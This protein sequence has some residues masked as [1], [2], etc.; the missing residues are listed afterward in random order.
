VSGDYRIPLDDRD[1]VRDLARV[2]REIIWPVKKGRN[3]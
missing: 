2:E 3:D 1:K